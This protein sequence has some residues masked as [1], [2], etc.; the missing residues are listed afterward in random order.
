MKK[1]TA[2]LLT[3]IFAMTIVSALAYEDRFT[4]D[5]DHCYPN[6]AVVVE[7]NRYEDI[8]ICVDYAGNEWIFEEVEDW[9]VGDIVSLMMFD[10]FT[11]SIRDD[12]II[13]AYYGGY[14]GVKT[15]IEWVRH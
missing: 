4:L 7:I 12:I 14:V 3:V 2:L 11:E 10:N 9:M 13:I 6:T 5:A 15:A 1:L 8:V